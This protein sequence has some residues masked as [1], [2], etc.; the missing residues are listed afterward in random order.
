MGKQVIL[1]VNLATAEV[2]GTTSAGR[3]LVATS[4][5]GKTKEVLEP[6]AGV[7]NGERVTFAGCSSP[8][9]ACVNNRIV[10]KIWKVLK[11]NED[12]VAQADSIIFTTSQGPVTVP[13]VA[14]GT[15]C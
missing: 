1:V 2:K 5:D 10:N 14:T 15:V 13:T 3:C 6:P 7:P 8:P 12:C 11:T 4:A 9:D